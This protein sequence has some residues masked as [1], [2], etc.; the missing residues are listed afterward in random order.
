VRFIRA[1]A[2]EV[3][4]LFVGDWAQTLVSVGI[5]MLGWLALSRIH[6]NGL[7]F[8]IVVALASQLIYATMLEARHHAPND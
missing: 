6:A 3:V 2:S 8:V 7:A 4:G 1:A 5:L